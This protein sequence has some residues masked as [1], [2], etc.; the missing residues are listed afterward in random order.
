MI[1]YYGPFYLSTVCA[2]AFE[3]R[4]PGY[5]SSVRLRHQWAHLQI[6][7]GGPLSF[8]VTC[9]SLV[10]VHCYYLVAAHPVY[11]THWSLSSLQVMVCCC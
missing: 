2:V 10:F 5:L 9:A 8:V 4:I 3:S 7:T 11:C 1:H 6:L